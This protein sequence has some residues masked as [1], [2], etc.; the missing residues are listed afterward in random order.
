MD[1]HTFDKLQ[2]DHVRQQL[3]GHCATALGKK[4][5][6]TIRP[7]PD[8]SQ[9]RKWLA[10]VEQITQS[11]PEVG[12]PPMAGIRD[13]RGH[14]HASDTPAGLSGEALAEVAETLAATGP[15]ADWFARLPDAAALVK[16]LAERVGNY[17]SIARAIDVAVDPRGQVRDS[18]SEKLAALRSTIETARTQVRVVIDRLLRQTRI[19]KLLQYPNA[20]IHE[21]R[22]VLPL[23]TEYRGR[24][25]G[26]IHRSS[27][28]G[29]TLFVEPAEAVELNNYIIRLR[30]D[31]AK[32]VGRI[33]SVLSHLVHLNA[34]AI[35]RSLDAIAVLDVLAAKLRYARQRDAIIPAISADKVLNLRQA[36]H[37]VLV[38]LLGRPPQAEGPADAA[39]RMPAVPPAEL[40]VLRSVV[41]IDVRLGDDFDVLV[42]TGPNTG[43]KTVAIK[44]VGLIALMAQAGIPIPA[45]PGSCL[46][47]YRNIFIDVGDEQSI[48]QSLSTFSSH[49]VNILSMLKR[50]GCDSLVLIDELG[51]G[52]DPD[53]GAAIGRAIMDELLARGCAG[54]VTTH[55]SALKG[56]AHTH[57]RVD[58]AAVEF[59]VATLRPTYRLLLGEPG[60]SNAI[61]V[62]ERLGMPANMA[63]AARQ[64]LDQQQR[65]LHDAIAGTVESRRAAEQA[66][67]E[68]EEAQLAAERS[69]LAFEG[70]QRRLAETQAAFER[71]VAWVNE[72]RPGDPVYIKSFDRPGR[73]VRVQLH[74]QKAV[75]AQGPMEL[76]VPFADLDFPLAPAE[77]A[78]R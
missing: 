38:D 29:A 62:A 8:A 60:N 51:A 7:S 76:E 17:T 72:L 6:T 63:R 45:A 56:V 13:I 66:R 78:K 59:D 58:N 2:F 3:A 52:T 16:R 4:L 71:W 28:S 34:P 27:D 31:E 54:I 67:R 41:P 9:V 57:P 40:P 70:Q 26:I 36:R 33:L 35:R 61:V 19:L 21:D 50:T 15:L 47:V 49:L 12:M 11:V 10:Q 42:I 32:E 37:P 69:R 22:M 74:N 68:A 25:P 18:A 39:A 43:G 65:A 20:T 64:H 24:I 53:E 46:P 30:I 73:I 77:S 1:S 75:V 5:A 44:T 14:L 23:K 48:E 55:L